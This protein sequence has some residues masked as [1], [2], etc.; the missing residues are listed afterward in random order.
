MVP[1]IRF[2]GFSEE[3]EETEM[4]KIAEDFYGGGTPKTSI[5]EYW[6]GNIPW[7]QT[8]DIIEDQVL[9]VKPQK[10]ISKI[11]LK[12]SA[13]K[14]VPE[15]SI[16]I[17][18]RVG[19]GKLSLIPFKYSTSQDF[20]SISK[21]K[22]NEIFAA[23]AIHKKMQIILIEVQ[24]TSIKGI[25]KEELLSKGITIPIDIKE[26][27]ILGNYFQNIDKLIEAN[28]NKLDKLK[29]IKK[30]CLEKMFPKKGA[31]VPEIRFKGF[32]GDWVEKTL[33]EI[34]PLQ[35]GFEPTQSIATGNVPIVYSN[36]ILNFHKRAKCEGPG[37]VT[38]R[39]GTIGKFTYIEGG[40]YWP[41]NT[42][43]WV[44]DFKGNVPIFIYYLYQTINI[45]QFATGSGVPTLN[46]ND[47]HV[48]KRFI[49]KTN[50][51]I[52]IGNYLKEIDKLIGISQQ[53]LT[54]LKNIK[55]ACLEK[56]FINKEDIL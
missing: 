20:L 39:S 25:T 45:I 12:E 32:S 18:T 3:W 5:N 37:L 31:T 21:L 56:M 28:Q 26:Q 19:V 36:G 53:Q 51:Q 6:N 49:P 17:I 10:H 38:G 29:N 34:A 52:L 54:K 27:A 22:I 2:K 42:T 35:R 9:G 1:K 46:R 13:T 47:V 23:Y 55:K 30:A 24:G 41:H 8:S 50:E 15:N 14:L 11:G 7:I 40:E 4:W 16:A 43:L 44:T 33:L 48:K